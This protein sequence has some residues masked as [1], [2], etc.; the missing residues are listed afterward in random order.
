MLGGGREEGGGGL[1][2]AVPLGM[3]TGMGSG[4]EQSASVG[5]STDDNLIGSFF[6]GVGFDCGDSMEI[7]IVLSWQLV[8]SQLSSAQATPLSHLT[9][10]RSSLYSLSAW[11]LPAKRGKA[12]RMKARREQTVLREGEGVVHR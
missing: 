7:C 2:T 9:C 8:V 1:F 3:V 4:S 11:V 12:S 10:L 5:G 6:E